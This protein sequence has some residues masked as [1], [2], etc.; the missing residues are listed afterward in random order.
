[1]DRCLHT[2]RTASAVANIDHLLARR[3]VPEVARFSRLADR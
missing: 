2:I 3:E 1:M